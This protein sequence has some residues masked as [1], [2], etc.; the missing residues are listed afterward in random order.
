MTL[1]SN[2]RWSAATNSIFSTC[3]PGGTFGKRLG[4]LVVHRDQLAIQGQVQVPGGRRDRLGG[5]RDDRGADDVDAHQDR[6]TADDRP[7]LRGDDGDLGWAARPRARGRRARGRR[8]PRAAAAGRQEQR[9]G[10]RDRPSA[11]CRLLM[12]DPPQVLLIVRW[13]ARSRR[14]GAARPF[15]VASMKNVQRPAVRVTFAAKWPWSKRISF[16]STCAPDG[17]LGAGG[18]LRDRLLVRAVEERVVDGV[19]PASSRGS[20]YVCSGRGSRRSAMV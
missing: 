19:R 18:G 15:V 4:R 7:L 6:W 17:R 9:G 10:N 20:T 13:S 11:A 16:V 8:R 2:G 1:G 3:C 5:L 12:P 14:T